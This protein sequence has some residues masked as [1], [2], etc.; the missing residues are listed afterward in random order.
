M[1]PFGTATDIILTSTRPDFKLT[2]LNPQKL[3]TSLDRLCEAPNLIEKVDYL[4]TGSLLVRAKNTQIAQKIHASISLPLPDQPVPIKAVYSWH[5]QFTYG[6]LYAPEFNNWPIDEILPI[7]EPYGVVG[8]RRLF[9]D[10]IKATVPLF[11]LTFLG[12]RPPS[13]KIGYTKYNIDQHIPNPMRCGKCC[14]W[15]HTTT[16]CRSPLTCGRCSARGHRHTECT[17]TTICCPNCKEEHE[18]NSKTCSHYLLELEACRLQATHNIGFPEARRRAR[19]PDPKNRS[20]LQS[21]P[22]PPPNR[23]HFPP[24][25]RTTGALQPTPNSPQLRRY[26]QVA[27]TQPR[28]QPSRNVD[29]PEAP[30]ASSQSRQQTTDLPY[31]SSVPPS[32][33]TNQYPTC[34]SQ[35]SASYNTIPETTTSQCSQHLQNL[36]DTC[37]ELPCNQEQLRRSGPSQ[38]SEQFLSPPQILPIAPQFTQ[39]QGQLQGPGQDSTFFNML[40]T[41]LPHLLKLFFA[42]SHT[43]KL[44][45]LVNLGQALNISKELNQVITTLDLPSPSSQLSS[46]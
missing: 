27:S 38:Y 21:T 5:H 4:P 18:V 3:A 23:T 46:Q 35:I 40:L 9:S 41:A 15:G 26:S 29:L 13:I 37:D 19:E 44:A 36:P 28:Q 20:L 42:A 39:S 22:A 10:P 43:D 25:K 2:S 1:T 17:A 7:L 16:K 32:A 12:S 30:I 34:S 24:L 8:V 6:K 31:S 14:R 33:T 11:V 45:A